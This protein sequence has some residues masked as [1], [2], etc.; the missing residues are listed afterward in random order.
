MQNTAANRR[1]V[2]EILTAA[3]E[4]NR[5]AGR[6]ISFV[7][8][9]GLNEDWQVVET[10]E[11]PEETEKTRAGKY[12]DRLEEIDNDFIPLEEN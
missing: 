11:E 7:C 6:K 4:I 3:K 2:N 5:K 8:A 9:E 10:P 12:W 1:L